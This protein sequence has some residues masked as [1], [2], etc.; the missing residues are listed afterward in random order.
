[1]NK[2]R[3]HH[4][5]TVI[6]KGIAD[7]RYYDVT[8]WTNCGVGWA[9]SDELFNTQGF[10]LVNNR[11]VFR[12][13]NYDYRQWEAVRKFFDL[14]K[15]QAGDLFGRFR[16]PTTPQAALVIIDQWLE[17]HWFNRLVHPLFGRQNYA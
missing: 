14:T 11:P 10:S 17:Q 16:G 5:R 13:S 1:M 3:I 2:D 12:Q 7:N 6:E 15:D 9:A 8:M 4:L